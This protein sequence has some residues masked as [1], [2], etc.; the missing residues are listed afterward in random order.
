MSKSGVNTKRASRRGVLYSSIADLA[1]DIDAIEAAEHAGTL[2]TTGNWTPAQNVGHCAA[3]WRAAMDGF[4]P[5]A[6][7]PKV[8]SLLAQWLFKSK[9]VGGATPPAG[10][11][12]PAA[13]RKVLVPDASITFDDAIGELRAQIMRVTDSGARFTKPSP[14][15]GTLTHEQWITIQL[16]HCQLH[17]GFLHLE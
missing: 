4:P 3:F 9:A 2:R 15:F 16:G 6:N 5:E 7:P 12:L 1:T 17:L 11:K 14:L 10:I 8:V 13:L